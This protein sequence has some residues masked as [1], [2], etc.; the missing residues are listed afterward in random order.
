MPSPARSI[1]SQ[2]VPTTT[3]E[4]TPRDTSGDA[5]GRPMEEDGHSPKKDPRSSEPVPHGFASRVRIAEDLDVD[6]ALLDRARRRFP[7][8]WPKY[9]LDLAVRHGNDGPVAR[10]G[11]PDPSELIEDPGDIADPISDQA[12][13]PVPFVVQKHPDRV[14]ILTTKKCHFYCRFCFRREEP[15]AKAMEPDDA[16]WARIFAFLEAHPAIEEPI[17]SGGDPLTLSNRQ[18]FALRDRFARIPSVKRWR[19]HTRAPVHYPAR[20]DE[21]LVAGLGQD[22]PLRVVTHFNHP[23]EITEESHRIARLF[24]RHGIELKNQT[25]LLAGIN[26]DPLTQERLWRELWHLGIRPHYIHH[27][28]RVAGNAMFRVRIDR[29]REIFAR[30]GASL[31]DLP[32]ALPRY[33][34]DLPD[35]SGKVPVPDLER[36]DSHRYRYRHPDGHLSHYRDVR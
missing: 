14:I 3:E 36:L 19:I 6:P 32:Q 10:L 26:D 18:L 2:T 28:D 24:A 11:K 25:V 33:V 29:G 34:I 23:H 20:V 30:L 16:D 7:V 4:R 17:L 22:L 13:R 5:L 1:L 8:Q 15:V 21:T 35:G 9:Y 12:K 31:A 27:P